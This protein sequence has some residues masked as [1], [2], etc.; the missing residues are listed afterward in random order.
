MHRISFHEVVDGYVYPTQ[1]RELATHYTHDYFVYGD[2]IGSSVERS[3]VKCLLEDTALI[4]RLGVE[5]RHESY[6]TVMLMFPIDSLNDPELVEIFEKLDD[7]PCISDEELSFVE[8]DMQVE[9]WESF[10]RRDFSSYL[11]GSYPDHSDVINDASDEDIDGLFG[12]IEQNSNYGVWSP[13]TGTGGYFDFESMGGTP[14]KAHALIKEWLN[15][16][17]QSCTL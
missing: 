1:F 2:Y 12:E 14:E 5:E 11:K 4:E 8:M 16:K 3:N 10:G 15:R 13:E 9:D 6:S 17:E 7:Y